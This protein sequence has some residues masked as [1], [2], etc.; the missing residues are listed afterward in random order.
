M[1]SILEVFPHIYGK[2]F[3]ANVIRGN[4]NQ[5][6]LKCVSEAVGTYNTGLCDAGQ[7]QDSQRSLNDWIY[8]PG[9]PPM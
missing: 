7:R 4:A 1:R 3:Q 6:C 9:G 2:A 8:H 5:I